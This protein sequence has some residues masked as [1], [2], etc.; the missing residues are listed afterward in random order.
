MTESNLDPA[1]DYPLSV[2]RNDLL[3]TPTGKSIDAITMPAVVAG[4]IEAADLRIT[5]D[6]LRLQA[7]ISEKVGRVQLGA[8]L[9][10]AAEMTAIS[11]ER[12]LEIY[13]ALRPNASTKE[14]LEAIAEEL[15]SQ[16]Q[17]ELLAE[18]VR[19]AAEVYERRDILATSE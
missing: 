19:E 3:F 7:Q 1:V 11:D 8:N 17:A 14:E 5:P 12:V 4:D 16:Y 9:R 13:N 6:T 2:N 10:R 18:L 15:S